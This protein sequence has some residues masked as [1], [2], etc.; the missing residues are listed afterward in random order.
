MSLIIFNLGVGLLALMSHVF[1]EDLEE[2]RYYRLRAFLSA[3]LS[4]IL[5][6]TS[7]L[8]STLYLLFYLFSLTRI[9]YLELILW[10]LLSA[11]SVEAYYFMVREALS[12]FKAISGA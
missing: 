1:R 7:F 11:C 9:E 10:L 5:V 8:A 2:L 3:R 4:L 6:F 12:A